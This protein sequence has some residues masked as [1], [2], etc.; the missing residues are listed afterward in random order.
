MW[1]MPYL[2]W[3]RIKQTKSSYLVH[4]RGAGSW[5]LFSPCCQSLCEPELS[6]CWLQQ[7]ID[8]TGRKIDINPLISLLARMQIIV[9][10]HI[11]ITTVCFIMTLW[12]WQNNPPAVVRGVFNLQTASNFLLIFPGWMICFLESVC[13]SVQLALR[14]V[15][16]FWSLC[17]RC[18]PI[19][20]G[21]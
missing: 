2:V 9:F 6:S 21:V 8:C 17:Q 16:L 5:I 7:H 10:P 18:Y 4:V 3:T 20:S 19:R 14:Y 1:N 12:V 15:S 13:D 11:S